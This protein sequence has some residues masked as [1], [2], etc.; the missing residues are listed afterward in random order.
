MCK[1][2]ELGGTWT[3]NVSSGTGTATG[4]GGELRVRL[5]RGTAEFEIYN[6]KEDEAEVEIFAETFWNVYDGSELVDTVPL[7]TEGRHRH[8][9]KRTGPNSFSYT[10][11][12]N[13][14]TVKVTF[15]SENTVRIE[16]TG[17]YKIGNGDEYRFTISFEMNKTAIPTPPNSNPGT[18]PI[19][20]TQYEFEALEGVWTARD[21]TAIASGYVPSYGNVTADLKLVNG[22]AVINL[23]GKS[24]NEAKI[25]G[26]FSFN[27]NASIAGV[28][29]EN[30]HLGESNLTNITVTRLGTNKFRY[31][32]PDGSSTIT[33]TMRS[34]ESAFVEEEGYYV[35]PGIN[36]PFKG[37]YYMDK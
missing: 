8:L 12:P 25:G 33:I 7:S 34:S 4:P 11:E 27:W 17:T 37:S 3:A 5:N 36:I 35:E 28:G 23:E 18:D 30:F 19:T 2:K 10:L 13:G 14:N 20:P 22:R 1:R 15:T 16:E 24:G 21:G 29:S 32:F 6:L 31:S 26:D 9:V